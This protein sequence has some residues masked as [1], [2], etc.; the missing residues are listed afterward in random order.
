MDIDNL[1]QTQQRMKLNILEMI[2]SNMMSSSAYSAVEF[3]CKI[4]LSNDYSLVEYVKYN[5][6]I[7]K[8]IFGILNS[9][10][11]Y[12]SSVDIG[13]YIMGFIKL[14]SNNLS[15]ISEV[16]KEIKIAYSL[17]K[18]L[19]PILLDLLP[20]NKLSLLMQFIDMILKLLYC[21]KKKFIY[22]GLA[23]ILFGIFSVN[24]GSNHINDKFTSQGSRQLN[25]FLLFF[26]M[27]IGE[28]L[29]SSESEVK[30]ID[31]IPPPESYSLSRNVSSFTC[32]NCNMS[33]KSSKENKQILICRLCSTGVCKECLL[34][35]TLDDNTICCKM[36]FK[37][38]CSTL[39]DDSIKTNKRCY[40]RLF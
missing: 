2:Y 24:K 35:E 1:S 37:G 39:T 4:V 36:Q 38:L 12:K 30:T 25:M 9:I 29:Y 27:K 7:S 6:Y 17:V 32:F 34:K 31:T 26:V 11:I 10:I 16:K 14:K 20:N 18:Y 19:L 40:I 5:K 33:N 28:W 15:P 21:F 13:D 3:I 22:F 23:E 8:V